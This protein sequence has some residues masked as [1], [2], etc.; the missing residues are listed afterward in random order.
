MEEVKFRQLAKY[1][2]QDT[3]GLP[4]YKLALLGDCA[5]QHLATAIKGYAFYE[6]IGLSVFDADYDQVYFQAM[7]KAS[8]LYKSEADAVLI[9]LCTERLYEE[10]CRTP[11]EQR[12]N[13]AEKTVEDTE[14][15]W[16]SIIQNSKMNILQFNFVCMDDAAF[17]S[18]GCK[19]ETGFAYQL[20]KLN[21][22]LYE[23]STRYKNV[24]TVDLNSVQTM[25]GR[26]CFY[27]AALYHVAKMPISLQALPQVAARVTD[28]VKALMGK[29]KKCV[30]L[31]LDNTLW[32][33]VIGDDGLAGIQIGQLGQGHAFSDFQ[34]W[35]K[36]LTKRG[37]ILAVCSKNNE[38]TAKE[39][40]EKHPEMV[41]KLSDIAM[42]VANWEDKA[43]NIK[44]I[45]QTLNIGV[46]SMVF[47]DDNK[48]ERN[49]VRSLVPGI[50]VPELP[51]DPAQYLEYVQ[52]LN[53]FETASY[54]AAD[55]DRTK[56]YQV[57][58][59]STA[60]RRK[61]EN[62]DDYL[63]SLDMQA[64]AAP[65]E[66]LHYARIA[67]LTQRSNQFNLRTVRYTE[68][69]I[70]SLAGNEGF[71]TLYFTL[72]DNQID[73][74]LISVVVLE[75]QDKET[76]FIDTWLMS[77]RVLKR[78]MEEFVINTIISFAKENGY[79]TVVGE[80]IATEKNSMVADIYSRMG[81]EDIGGGKFRCSTGEFKPHEVFIEK[82]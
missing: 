64:V 39:P 23:K 56:Q 76:L 63:K 12:H 31:D 25:L 3:N 43:G 70:E 55:K 1:A 77:C 41:L 81:F 80:Y 20:A 74:G 44:M 49:M 17:G 2:K 47:L 45:Q 28:V 33:G 10:F 19:V 22:L 37:I 40:F 6:G 35:L 5:T 24:F 53:L 18:F 73:H 66:P 69:D 27:D 62:I 58:V 59:E 71:L 60:L 52:S 38:A 34:L 7:D 30:V 15:N 57:E 16:Q 21:Y 11:E 50:T 14:T 29:V 48:F 32:G 42:F 46:D 68:A 4:Q 51:E 26:R 13:F 78:G 75:K 72:K 9:Y 67:Q 82:V 36:E 54:S 65:F 79:K 61:F 8:E